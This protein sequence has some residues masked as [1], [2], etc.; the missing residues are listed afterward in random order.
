VSILIDRDTRL[1]V[2]GITGR[3]G[4][5]HSR[6]MLE[7]G[8]PL[9]AGVTPGKGGQQVLDGRVPV[10]NT[11][12]EAV[13]ETGAN[14]S[15]IFVPAGGAPDAVLESVAAGIAT[16]FC[17]TEGIP[18]L[19]MIPVV[20][21]VRLAG[22]TL[23]GPNC[24]G[25]T[26]PGTA[27]VGII[28]GS[29]HREGRVGVVSRSGTLTYEAVQAMTDA[30]LGQSTCVG[31]GGDP[32]IGTQF[33]GILQLF[34]ADPGTDAIVLIG[35]IGGAAEEEAA[36]WAA[37]HLADVPK[38]AF[39]AG[40]TA[41][42]GKRMGHAG[43]IISGGRGTAA[44]KVSALEAAGFRVAGSPTELPQLLRDAGSRG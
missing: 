21:E 28:P 13:R 40:R 37:E 36:A 29:I 5:F 22:A 44:S 31:I 4:E 15:C 14:T 11:V 10:F 6:A 32:V 18:A 34:A 1:V 19:D 41:P 27:K 39:I 2:Q 3:E 8:T 16:I 9:V 26:S 25:A 42:E 17:I 43:A 20:E 7:Y 38:V 24:P 12:A 35:E 30:G 33:L 23:I